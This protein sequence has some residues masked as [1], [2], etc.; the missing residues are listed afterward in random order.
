MTDPVQNEQIE[1]PQ[2]TEI[3]QKAMEMG[4]RP[5]DEFNGDDVDF[6]DAKEFVARKPLYDKIAQQSKTVKNIE[7]TLGALR[8][9]NSK[10]AEYEYN[11]AM[12]DLK[13]QRKE[14]LLQ[15]DGDALDKAED[16]IQEVQEKYAEAQRTAQQMQVQDNEPVL[17]PTFIHWKNRNPWYDSTAYMRNFADDLGRKLAATGITP[18]EI[19]KE[20]EKAVQKE[21]PTKFRNPN[22]ENAPNVDTSKGT[23]SSSKGQ[24]QLTEQEHKIWQNLHRMDPEKFS[25]EKY[26]AE[27]KKV[28]GI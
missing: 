6:V 18:E 20:V 13:A 5:K 3:E 22:K 14:A 26:V 7:K 24:Y 19:L 23:G 15:G 21:F 28:K 1:Q 4:W 16:Q 8:E 27:L 17:N 25:R 12:K 9:H 11:R 2:Y 10:I